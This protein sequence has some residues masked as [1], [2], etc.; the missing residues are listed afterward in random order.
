MIQVKTI[1]G[2]TRRN[3]L[4]SELLG[5]KR[6][7]AHNPGGIGKFLNFV[8]YKVL[9][10]A[11]VQYIMSGETNSKLNFLVLRFSRLTG[12]KVLG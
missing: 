6:K 1:V 4:H 8:Q 9:R 3:T 11:P 10:V 2:L 7:S 5:M 12:Q